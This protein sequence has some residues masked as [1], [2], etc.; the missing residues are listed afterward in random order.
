MEDNSALKEN[1]PLLAQTP[2]PPYYAVIF[3]SKR[4]EGDQ[5]YNQM[6]EKIEELVKKQTGF[7]GME[8]A[9]NQLGITVSYW[10]DMASIKNW[11]ENME[12]R[13]AKKQ[14]QEKWY[15]FYRVRI[16][17]VEFEY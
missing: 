6:S 12:H 11:S 3:T 9:R 7:L 16:S 1:T 2:S 15:E 4:T 8:S 13:E 17:K 10:K 5:D 14:G